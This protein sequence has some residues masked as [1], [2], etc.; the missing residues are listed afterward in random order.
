MNPWWQRS[1]TIAVLVVSVTATV[2]Y[3]ARSRSEEREAWQRVRGRAAAMAAPFARGVEA[4]APLLGAAHPGFADRHYCAPTDQ[5]GSS[6]RQG[7]EPFLYELLAMDE[8]PP[9]TEARLVRHQ[10]ALTELAAGAAADQIDYSTFRKVPGIE[11]K[12]KEPVGLL[13][14]SEV[15]TAALLAARRD[16]ATGRHSSAV[17]RTADL[18]TV[19]RDQFGAGVPI[20][21]L[22]AASYVHGVCELWSDPRLRDLPAAEQRQLAEVLLRFDTACGPATSCVSCA[23]QHLVEICA[24]HDDP[25]VGPEQIDAHLTAVTALPGDEA[26]WS[27]RQPAL[28]AAQAC[29]PQSCRIDLVAIECSRR[30]AIARVRLLRM[31][32]AHHLGE[33]VPVLR[34]PFG[35]ES[36]QTS[37]HEGGL[38][39]ASSGKGAGDEPI[40]RIVRAR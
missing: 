29:L 3:V 11:H 31:A 1:W 33:R 9:E 23:A 36:L 14:I 19:A 7:D 2:L 35:E 28:A 39:F 18:L 12:G 8:L 25:P 38:R 34:D 24:Q 16:L 26:P 5:F 6:T 17:Q 27:A 4:H 37:E 40:E 15:G 30:E 22:F 13:A 21:D 32:V 20:Y 10:A